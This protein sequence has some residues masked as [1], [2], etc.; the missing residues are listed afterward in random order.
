MSKN[1]PNGSQIK[2]N[3]IEHEPA[4]NLAVRESKPR[5]SSRSNLAEKTKEELALIRK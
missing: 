4:R 2:L 3:T 5:D 1:A